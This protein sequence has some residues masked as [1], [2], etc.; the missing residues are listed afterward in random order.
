MVINKFSNYGFHHKYRKAPCSE[1]VI[2]FLEAWFLQ[3]GRAARLCSDG[4]LHFRL[5][6]NV[7]CKSKGMIHK[8]TAPYCPQSKGPDKMIPGDR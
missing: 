4:G 8:L 3:V 6:F 7:Y 2:D 1:E 5:E